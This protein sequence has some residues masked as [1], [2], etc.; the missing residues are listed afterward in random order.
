MVTVGCA[1]VKGA[2][3]RVKRGLFLLVWNTVELVAYL[4]MFYTH[5]LMWMALLGSSRQNPDLIDWVSGVIAVLNVL[6]ACWMVY[7]WCKML[8]W[9]WVPREIRKAH[10]CTNPEEA[11]ARAASNLALASVPFWWA[12]GHMY[13]VIWLMCDYAMDSG[14]PP[15]QPAGV[16][17]SAVFTFNLAVALLRTVLGVCMSLAPT[18][19]VQ[20]WASHVKE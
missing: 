10:N 1:P 19:C 6:T 5:L 18:A 12:T 14:I 17:F 2:R 8:W 20:R 16:G 4:N 7:L 11:E 13:C 3:T 9:L 15:W